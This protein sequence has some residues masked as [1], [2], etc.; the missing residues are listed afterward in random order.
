V[1][2]ENLPFVDGE[3]GTA[4]SGSPPRFWLPSPR[5][6]LRSSCFCPVSGSHGSWTTPEHKAV[7]PMAQ[8]ETVSAGYHGRSIEHDPGICAVLRHTGSENPN[9]FH[10]LVSPAGRAPCAAHFYRRSTPDPLTPHTRAA[11]VAERTASPG[12][13]HAHRLAGLFGHSSLG[14]YSAACRGF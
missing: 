1:R 8:K 10:S 9:T 12:L 4:L 14:S 7:P 2:Y 6:G 11:T 3:T 5:C 13:S